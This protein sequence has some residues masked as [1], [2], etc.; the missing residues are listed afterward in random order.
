MR[1]IVCS[2]LPVH[3]LDPPA[4]PLETYHMLQPD[5]ML[6]VCALFL[7]CDRY[8]YGRYTGSC[9]SQALMATGF[10]DIR[11][12][13][14]SFSRAHWWTCCASSRVRWQGIGRPRSAWMR[15]RA[16]RL[17]GEGKRPDR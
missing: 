16:A 1:A 10:G 12:S 11:V 6:L 4:V 7:H 13:N 5:A 8:D 2:E 15:Q 17:T 3:I 14:S 9:R